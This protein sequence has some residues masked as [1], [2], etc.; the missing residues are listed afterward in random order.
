MVNYLDD[1]FFAALLE[2]LCNEQVKSFLWVCEEIN[3]PGAE[4]KTVWATN[5]LT[6]L[7]L[8]LDS[9]RQLV[10]IPLEKLNRAKELINFF[11]NKKNKKATVLQF[12]KL[13]GFLNFLCRCIVPGRTFLRRLYIATTNMGKKLKPHYRVRISEENRMDLR[14]WQRFLEY[15]LAFARPFMDFNMLTASVIDMYSDASRNFNLGFGAYCGTEWT[16]G[17]WD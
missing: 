2:A 13:C 5:L 11:L 14:V 17:Q 4:E 6:F 16:F 7:G 10:C 9:E 12:Q 15:P 3:F 8:L 1:Y